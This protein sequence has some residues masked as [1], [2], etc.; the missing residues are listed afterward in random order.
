MRRKQFKFSDATA[1][2]LR[3]MK[4]G[5]E[6][7]EVSVVRIGLRLAQRALDEAR[8][9][10]RLAVVEPGGRIVELSGEWEAA[11]RMATV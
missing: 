2:S 4:A 6:T 10:N 1:A 9:G 5:Y 11:G 7:N 3:Q 8:R